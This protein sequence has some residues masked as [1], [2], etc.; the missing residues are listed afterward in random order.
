MRQDPHS[1]A[2]LDQA[3]VERVELELTVDFEARRLHGEATLFFAEPATGAVDLDCRGLEIGGILDA[4]GALVRFELGRN[5]PILGERLRLNLDRTTP[6]VRMQYATGADASGLMWLSPDQTN[7]GEHP[8]L[9]SQ[10]QAI[11]ARSLVPLQDTP[12]A[13]IT[14]TAR[15]TVPAFATVV[16]SAAPG[17]VEDQGDHRTFA[18][19]MPQPIPPYLLALAAGQ[20]EARDLGPRCRVFAEPGV[21]EAAAWE[22]E[23]V[24]RML[25][26][27]E[28]LFGPYPWERYDFI[29]LPPSFPMGGMENPRMTFLTPTLLAGDRSL[30]G[31]LAHE[32]AHSWTGNLVSNATNEDFWLNEGWTVW[33]ERRILEHLYGEEEAVQQAVLGRRGLDESL[34]DHVR[35]GANTAL[36]FDQQGLD[37]DDVFSRIPYEKG[38][39]LITALE[40]AAGRERFDAFVQDY[41]RTFRFQSI[42]TATFVAFVR[43]E[44][45]EAAGVDLD[46]WLH[47]QGLPDDAP[48][49]RSARLDAIA[50]QAAAGQLPEDGAGWSTT[51]KLTYLDH[52]L[53]RIDA[54]A[55]SAAL[56]IDHRA[57]AEVRSAWL[58]FAV[59]AGT[60]ALEPALSDLLDTVGRTKLLKPVVREMV[61]RQDLGALARTLVDRNHA[62]FHSSTRIA[63][64]RELRTVP[65]A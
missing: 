59:R 28:E 15:I 8:F 19:E 58:A 36:T 46:L 52:L 64:E 32:L 24:D 38:C 13:R 20:L 29:V 44:L 17:Q 16:M 47:E 63:L 50:T 53:P 5:D 40:R 45:P 42:D 18:F 34:A 11:H 22:F 61:A 51:E 9:L 56:G 2:D 41:I 43:S 48:T 14:T 31:V 62:R 54:N 30:V 7:G 12:R 65:T 55:V 39:L 1:Y 26:A 27:A 33:A 23:D 25:C 10:C 21:V 37:P 6:Y 49:F 60:T 57:N 3:R 35:R 4:Q